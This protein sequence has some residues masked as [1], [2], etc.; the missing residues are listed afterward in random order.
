MRF[1][2]RSWV[3]PSSFYPDLEGTQKTRDHVETRVSAPFS[4]GPTHI[5]CG[6][7]RGLRA[8]FWRNGE[9]ER[10]V[11][12]RYVGDSHYACLNPLKTADFYVAGTWT[13]VQNAHTQR[14][15]SFGFSPPVIALPTEAEVGI[16]GPVCGPVSY[17]RPAVS[18]FPSLLAEHSRGTAGASERATK[19]MSVPS[20]AQ[21]RKNG[22]CSTFLEGAGNWVNSF[23]TIRLESHFV[24]LNP[25]TGVKFYATEA[26]A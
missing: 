3:S 11:P 7:I 24:C 19:R 20:M 2:T 4:L 13:Q 22:L 23:P 18:Y 21:I 16:S 15:G 1:S 8:R 5:F 6:G 12:R 9:V 10:T 25:P 14:R 17:F 26:W